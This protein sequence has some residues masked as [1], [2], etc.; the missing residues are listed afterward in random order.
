MLDAPWVNIAGTGDVNFNDESLHFRLV[1]KSNGFSLASLRGPIGIT[2]TFSSPVARPELGGV[3]ARSGLAVCL[4]VAT[5]G[6]GGLIPLLDFGKNSD[7]NYSAFINRA[8]SDAGVKTGDSTLVKPA[9][10]AGTKVR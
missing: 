4:G 1:A 2:G 5:R 6:I 9:K 7:S 3:V 8:K 10:S